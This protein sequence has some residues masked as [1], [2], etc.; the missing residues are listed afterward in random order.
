MSDI[1]LMQSAAYDVQSLGSLKQ[2]L[3]EKPQEGLRQVTQQLEAT[4]VQ[5][6]LKSMRAALPQDGLFSSDQT[7]MLTSMYDQQI[8]QTCQK[9]GWASAI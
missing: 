6:M 3:N 1:Q 4:F 5:M 9:R 7:R 2:Q 8:A